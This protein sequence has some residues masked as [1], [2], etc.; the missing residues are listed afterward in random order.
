MALGLC[1]KTYRSSHGPRT[2]QY[3]VLGPECCFS[4][5]DLFNAAEGRT[6]TPD[7]ES[8]FRALSQSEKNEWVSRL[9]AKASQFRTEDKVGTDGVTYRAFWIE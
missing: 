6:W 7:E 4:F 5:A 9:A 8:I 1:R 3:N 2:V